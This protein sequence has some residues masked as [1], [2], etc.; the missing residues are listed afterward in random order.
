MVSGGKN[1]PEIAVLRVDIAE[2]D[3]WEANSGKMIMG[4]RYVAAAVTGGS[5]PVGAPECR[6]GRGVESLGWMPAEF[7]SRKECDSAFRILLRS[8]L[9]SRQCAAARIF[10]PSLLWLVPLGNCGMI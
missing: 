4:I 10:R 7:A 2:G 8:R 1:D 9:E 3:F 5:V 6:P